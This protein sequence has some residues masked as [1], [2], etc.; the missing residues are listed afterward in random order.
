MHT[1]SKQVFAQVTHFPPL[2]LPNFIVFSD[3]LLIKESLIVKDLILG[4]LP[5]DCSLLE[6]RR[7]SQV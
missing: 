3:Q 6:R 4:V 7:L 1:I 2:K 5:L